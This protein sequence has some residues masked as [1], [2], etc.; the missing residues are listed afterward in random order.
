MV[1]SA[2]ADMIAWALHSAGLKHLIHYL[3]D[4]L[5]IGAPSTDE[6]KEALALALWILEYLGVPVAAHKTE[7]PATVVTF[8]GILVDTRT[9]ELRLPQ[10]KIH[11]L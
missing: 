8:L 5:F 1:F 9:F 3:D 2:I 7:G 10:D 11:H 6:G 4:F